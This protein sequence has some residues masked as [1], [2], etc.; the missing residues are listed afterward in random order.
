M[1][2]FVTFLKGYYGENDFVVT[3][4]SVFQI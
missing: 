1:E 4:I 3:K 2:E